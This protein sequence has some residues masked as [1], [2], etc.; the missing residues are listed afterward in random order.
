MIKKTK[1]VHESL[2]NRQL[3]AVGCN[4]IHR[5]QVSIDISGVDCTFDTPVTL[6]IATT[7]ALVLKVDSAT[8]SLVAKPL[9]TPTISKT[10]C[11]SA[12][13]KGYILPGCLEDTKAIFTAV[14]NILGST[15]VPNAA[16]TKCTATISK[17]ITLP[18]STLINR[19]GATATAANLQFGNIIADLSEA[20][21][22]AAVFATA[23]SADVGNAADAVVSKVTTGGA[24]NLV[25]DVCSDATGLSF[26]EAT[27]K[28]AVGA[29]ASL[30]IQNAGVPVEWAITK[31]G[32]GTIATGP[33]VEINAVGFTASNGV[34]GGDDPDIGTAIAN[35][36]NVNLEMLN[37]AQKEA[38][39]NQFSNWKYGNTT[40]VAPMFG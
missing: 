23:P 10:L 8:V 39:L 31:T 2:E 5:G 38:I 22:V 15:D 19:T 13:A 6:A 16:T 3:L 37:A 12:D 27:S 20:A 24:L 29:Y 17:E 11:E 36:K 26:I 40:N 4:E 18:K 34:L 35:Y 14:L 30:L 25:F 28:L 1:L 9:A 7:D 32:A 21:N 33:T